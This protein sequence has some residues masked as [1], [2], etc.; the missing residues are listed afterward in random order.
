MH[1]SCLKNKNK[2]RDKSEMPSLALERNEVV[3]RNIQNTLINS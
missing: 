2:N 1:K 3:G